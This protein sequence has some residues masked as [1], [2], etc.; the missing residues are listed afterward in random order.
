MFI[1]EICNCAFEREYSP[2]CGKQLCY[3]AFMH[4]VYDG[5]DNWGP[6]NGNCCPCNSPNCDGTCEKNTKKKEV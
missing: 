2:I 1:C 5:D 6:E 4:M 3:D